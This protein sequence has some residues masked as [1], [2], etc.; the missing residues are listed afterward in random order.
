MP[1]TT[2]FGFNQSHSLVQS[3]CITSVPLP[4]RQDARIRRE[5]RA[6]AEQLGQKVFW[7]LDPSGVELM[8]FM[9]KQSGMLYILDIDRQDWTNAFDGATLSQALKRGDHWPRPPQAL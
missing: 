8:V 7:V 4:P 5:Q 9:H 1:S 6:R 3:F 2:S